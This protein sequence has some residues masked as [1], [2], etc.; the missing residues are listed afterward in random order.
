MEADSNDITEHPR[1]KEPRPL[2]VQCATN[3]LESKE[4]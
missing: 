3:G 2:S 4:L 1:D